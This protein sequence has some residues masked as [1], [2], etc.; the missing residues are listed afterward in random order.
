ML[1]SKLKHRLYFAG[2]YIVRSFGGFA[3]A[4]HLTRNSLR[5]LCYHGFSAGDEFEILPMMF[6]RP[7]TFERRM[8][9]LARHRLPVVRLSEAVS[10]L[11][12]GRI[13]K[14]ETVITLDDGWATN[15]TLA[16]PILRRHAYAACVYVTTAH[17][18][19]GTQAF[20]VALYYMVRS[21]NRS[22][23]VLSGIHPVVDGSYDISG[24]D[25]RPTIAR[26]VQATEQAFSLEERQKLLRP[27]AAALG[28]DLDAVFK[29]GRLKFLDAA[30]IRQLADHGVEIQ[31]HTHTHRLPD[32]TFEA[33]SWEIR[34][35]QE[36]LQAITGAEAHHFCYPSGE[37]AAVHPEWL[38][39]LGLLSAVTCDPGLNP[40]GTSTMLLKRYLDSEV[41][42]EIVFEA[43]ICGLRELIRN[44]R[45]NIQRL[46]DPLKSWK[47]R[48]LV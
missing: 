28:L 30:Q 26:L 7:V 9:I 19:A 38:T 35:N 3:L 10:Q 42:P 15:L 25:P 6:M 34:R 40:A 21:S 46:M 5:I 33:M 1:V 24:E 39:R 12:E 22:N 44:V 31:L 45:G 48:F 27:I 2:L 36:A 4:K 8:R 37:H 13:S 16:L 14:G 17:L 29:D 18:A 11:K 43:E 20:N 32:D 23:L 47:R 41:T